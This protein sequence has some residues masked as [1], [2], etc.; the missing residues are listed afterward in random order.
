MGARAGPSPQHRRLPDAGGG[1]RRRRRRAACSRWSPARLDFARDYL[2]T[3]ATRKKFEAFARTLIRPLF[4]QLGFAPQAADNDE[5]RQLRAVVIGSLG[6]TGEDADVVARSRAALDK[7]LAGGPALDPTLAAPIVAVAAEHGDA[8]LYD[9]LKAASDRATAPDDHYR[10]L[11]ALA[12]FRDPALIDRGLQ[13]SL[14]PELRSQDAA[15][16]LSQFFGNPVA[17]PRAWAFAKQYWD[18]LAPKLTIFGGD[19]NFTAALSGFCDAGARD[20]IKTFFA[21]HKMSAATR[22]LDQTIER[23]NNC[24]DLRERQTDDADEVGGQRQVVASGW[25]RHAA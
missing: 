3:D 10:Y 2:T 24:I 7:A 13:D 20:D 25:G 4:D 8:A 19:T 17:R 6:T 18:V 5:Q 15:I 12:D 21:A 22:T 1:L 14:S 9:A 16:Y 23:I 11:Y